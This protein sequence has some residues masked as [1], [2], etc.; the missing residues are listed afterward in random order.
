MK[1]MFECFNIFFKK[2]EIY[3]IF[4]FHNFKFIVHELYKQ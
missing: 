1:E 2:K 3:I 4:N